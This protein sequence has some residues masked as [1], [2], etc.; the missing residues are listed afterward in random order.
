MR[1][2]ISYT[3]YPQSKKLT[4]KSRRIAT[5][6]HP[7]Y[8]IILGGILGMAAAFVFPNSVAIPMICL[9]GGPIAGV[10]L[11]RMLRNKKFAQYD[12]E[13]AALLSGSKQ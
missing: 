7:L 10:I 13:Y 8:G 9:I 11:L 3:N 2:R 1:M 4:N 5:F 6:T 12:A